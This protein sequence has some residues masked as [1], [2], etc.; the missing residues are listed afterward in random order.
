M[1]RTREVC[2]ELNL[3]KNLCCGIE[4]VLGRGVLFPDCP[5]HPK[6]TTFWKEA[7]DRPMLKA[8][9]LSEKQSA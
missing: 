9:D 8:E 2:S 5:K 7:I 1:P 4:V 3:Y 6:R